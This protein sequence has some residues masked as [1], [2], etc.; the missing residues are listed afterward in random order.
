MTRAHI[1]P[2]D[3]APPFAKAGPSA[4]MRTHLASRSARAAAA[5]LAP[6]V[7]LI[8]AFTRL[9]I[10]IAVLYVVVVLLVAGTGSQRATLLSGVAC[11]LLT[12]AGFLLSK[13]L[14]PGAGPAARCAISLLA[15][16]TITLL[17][18][19]NLAATAAL[20]RSEAFLAEAQRLSRTGSIAVRLPEGSMTWSDEAYRI[21][22]YGRDVRPDTTHVLDRVHPD[23]VAQVRAAGDRMRAGAPDVSVAHRLLLPDGTVR[24]VH[25]VAR[26][27]AAEAGRTEYVGAL[28]DVTTA[29]QTQR[30]LE[31]SQADL[32][33]ATRV[34]TLGELATSIA[35]EVTQ[36]IA[37]I[38]TCGGSALRW[39]D[40]PVPDL[41][42]ARRS[43]A[44][45]IRDAE[46]AGEIVHRIRL[47]A[48]RQAPAVDMVDL[49][50]LV[51][52][53]LSVVRRE[54]QEHRVAT[55]LVLAEP[56]PRIAGDRIQLQ[57]VLL[58]LLLNAVQAMAA[59]DTCRLRMTT[60]PAERRRVSLVVEDTGP[61]FRPEDTDKLFTAFYTT[62]PEGLG[63]G[64]SICR[65]IV[66]AHG[67]TIHAGAA[68]G[69]GARLALTF[70]L[71]EDTPS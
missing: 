58:N 49:N 52:E 18:L 33:H 22:G 53:S 44:Q 64:L 9:D 26:L 35:H 60:A 3:R 43:V 38:A 61:G 63:M 23:D 45:M 8:D 56:A 69:G 46:R 65:S 48:R 20:A 41:P 40:R 14:H 28:M 12:L 67:G 1:P 15:I 19:R 7:F 21:F 4:P 71:P 59:S 37:A 55:E 47:M 31:R 11:G 2:Y 54:L 70:P 24:H 68:P 13:H 39:L 25:L 66:E 16:A 62:R 50:R 6:A 36:P 10:A 27:T 57:Q 51:R 42:E 30:A 17:V 29:V 32:A 34:T 5:I